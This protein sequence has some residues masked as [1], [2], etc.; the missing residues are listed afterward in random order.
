MPRTGEA[1]RLW[2]WAGNIAYS[3]QHLHR[4]T[5]IEELQELVATTPSLR[6]LGSRHSFNRIADTTGA[7]VSVAGLPGDPVIF[8]DG[9]RVSVGAGVPY[10]RLAAHLQQHGLALHN[11]GSLPHITVAGACATGTHGSGVT[12]GSLPTAVSAVEF[13]RGDGELVRLRR[14]DDTFPGAV[15]ALGALG[16]VTR[17]ELET[18]PSYDVRQTVWVDASLERVLA[19]L[20]A[21]VGAAY[22]VSLFTHWDGADVVDQLWFKQRADEPLVDASR[23]GARPAATPQHPIRGADPAAATPQDGA[24]G[25]WHTRLPHFRFE[26]VP[27]NGE[28]QQSEFFVERRH[29]ADAIAAL[30]GLPLSPALQVCEIRTIAADELWLSPCHGRDALALH[31]TWVDDD[32]LV[33]PAVTAVERALAPFD[34]RPHW[35]K[36]FVA[37][38]DEVRAHYPQLAKFRELAAA[39]DPGRRFGSDFLAAFV[40]D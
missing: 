10:G 3:T 12:N 22:S 27:S 35:G 15:L 8:A 24:P 28:E 26:H 7:L 21:V 23:W 38:A 39:C 11:L 33:T 4:P 25:P 31:F 32:D 36:V 19:D 34:P 17:L 20:D 14:G 18:Q 16:V 5:S 30:R 13:V 37:R 29:G 6:P 9:T 1:N 2:N 40:Y